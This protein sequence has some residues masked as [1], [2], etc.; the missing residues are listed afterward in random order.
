ME[1]AGSRR[2][3]LDGRVGRRAALQPVC[4]HLSRE[5]RSAGHDRQLRAP[6][7]RR[8]TIRGAR[9]PKS[10][11]ASAR[12]SSTS[13]AGPSASTSA[14]RRSPT[15]AAFRAWWSAYLR[16]GA[17]PG[18]AVALTRMNAE[19]DM[20][21]V[22]PS[23]RVPTLVDASHRRSLPE[24]RGGPLSRVAHPGR[25][26]RRAARRSITCRSSAIRTRCSR[27]SKSS[28]RAGKR[29]GRRPPRS[30]RR[31]A[32]PASGTPAESDLLRRLFDR[33][34]QF[35]RGRPVAIG[36]RITWW[37]PSTDPAAPFNARCR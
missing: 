26:F 2:A 23:I 12:R 7:A 21:D 6:H 19:I 5:D 11:I 25:D 16:M 30:P 13:G 10:A 17:S 20:R 14:R 15:I 32:S 4:R 37:R 29:R 31:S 28:C 22:L 18:A 24:G 36:R 3:V 34:C 1:A 27:R 9:R 35:F 8:A 33:E